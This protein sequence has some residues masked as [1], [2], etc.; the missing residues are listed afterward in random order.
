MT[1]VDAGLEDMESVIRPVKKSKLK[2][3]QIDS[4]RIEAVFPA[5]VLLVTKTH[6][7]LSNWMT[8]FEFDYSQRMEGDLQEGLSYVFRAKWDSEVYG[9]EGFGTALSLEQIFDPDVERYHFHPLCL[10]SYG[11]ER[12]RWNGHNGR[13][14]VVCGTTTEAAGEKMLKLRK[15]TV[16][17][18]KKSGPYAGVK[19][20]PR[21]CYSWRET[22]I[23]G[24]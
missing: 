12:H 24:A 22:V 5:T 20:L 19:E 14:E 11:G 7:H 8:A 4:R 18:V 3:R 6:I 1:I 17:L 23:Q 2:C 16:P 9:V 21:G 15:D 13:L 10:S